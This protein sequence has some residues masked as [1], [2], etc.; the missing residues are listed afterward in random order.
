[1]LLFQCR[2]SKLRQLRG[3]GGGGGGGGGVSDGVSLL[4]L[5]LREVFVVAVV[6]LPVPLWLPLV[7]LLPETEDR[8]IVTGLEVAAAT[9]TSLR[10][11]SVRD[12][13]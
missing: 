8:F 13:S 2:S 6:P 4:I 1:M 3:G 11:I 7:L 5:L 9:S 10:F 12:Y